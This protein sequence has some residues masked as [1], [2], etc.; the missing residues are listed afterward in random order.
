VAEGR[1]SSRQRETI[2]RRAHYCCEYCKSQDEFSTQSFSVEHIV[3]RSRGG[4]TTLENLAFSC[5][6]CN[7]AK[8]TKTQGID[9]VTKEA[10]P[11][12]HP[13]Q[14]VWSD[15]FAWSDDYTHI[16]GL[17]PSGRATV[18]TLDLN[19]SRLIN[20][21]RVLYAMGEHPPVESAG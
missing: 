7:N 4:P 21:R 9:P 14:Q 6:C 5:Q 18:A 2:A 17:T 16:V 13:R 15:H 12:F 20:L 10:V 19:R 1:P 8:Y 11:L 3:P